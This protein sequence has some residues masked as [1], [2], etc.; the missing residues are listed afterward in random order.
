LRKGNP[1]K[2]GGK[3]RKSIGILLLRFCPLRKKHRNQNE[4]KEGNLTESFS[5]FLPFPRKKGKKEVATT[6]GSSLSRPVKKGATTEWGGRE[7]PN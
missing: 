1:Q 5:T 6:T 2:L 3:D 4:K 7:I